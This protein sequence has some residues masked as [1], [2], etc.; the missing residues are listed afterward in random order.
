MA[1]KLMPVIRRV[2][3][4][5]TAA[6]IVERNDSHCPTWIANLLLA[7][8]YGNSFRMLQLLPNSDVKLYWWYLLAGH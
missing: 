7:Y 1:V 8:T 6:A 3:S 4:V 5:T 2:L